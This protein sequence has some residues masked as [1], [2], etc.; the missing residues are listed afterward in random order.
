MSYVRGGQ[1]LGKGSGIQYSSG[2]PMQQ[3]G[4]ELPSS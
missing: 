1:M 4:Q 2:V 3:Y